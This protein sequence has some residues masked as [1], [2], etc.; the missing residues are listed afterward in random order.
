MDDV[1]EIKSLADE[2]EDLDDD[3][4]SVVLG[5]LNEY[6]SLVEPLPEFTAPPTSLNAYGRTL[7]FSAIATPHHRNFQ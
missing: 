3:K 4:E 5:R 2:D 7:N 1:E 6:A